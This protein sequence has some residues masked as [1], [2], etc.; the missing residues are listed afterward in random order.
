MRPSRCRQPV[1]KQSDGAVARL[2]SACLGRTHLSVVLGDVGSGKSHL[3]WWLRRLPAQRRAAVPVGALPDLG[4]PFRYTLRQ[5]RRRCA[6]ATRRA[7]KRL[8]RRP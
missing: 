2:R 1:R 4:Q 6:S 5:L 7:T 3:L 8:R